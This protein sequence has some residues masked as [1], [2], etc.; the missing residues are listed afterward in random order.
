MEPAMQKTFQS[1][2]EAGLLLSKKLTG[3]KF[4]NAVVVGIPRGG[5]CV[6]QVIAKEL[7]LPLEV[8]PCKTIHHPANAKEYIGSVCAT[9][10][11]IHEEAYRVPQDYIA[12]QISA[13]QHTL[14]REQSLYYADAELPSLKYK[15]VILVD[16]VMQTS[17]SILAC[18]RNIRK[19]QPLKM[20][21]A[22]PVVSAEAARII[23]SEVSE[24]HFLKMEPHILPGKEYF[25][26]YPAIDNSTV[27]NILDDFRKSA[28]ARN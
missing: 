11:F 4:T 19:Q 21:V 23:G 7:S 24:I 20:M 12:H 28:T 8:M 14:R 15:T 3:L 2:E 26:H 9:D 5:V 16:D 27:K 1:R 18:I 25:R 13:L 22:V 10:A 6:A 17:D